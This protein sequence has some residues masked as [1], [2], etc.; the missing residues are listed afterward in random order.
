VA[1]RGKPGH[2]GG[3]GRVSAA[4]EMVKGGLGAG[5]LPQD[6]DVDHDAGAPGLVF[7]PGLVVRAEPAGLPSTPGSAATAT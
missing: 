3:A 7:L 6:D 2:G 4:S 1:E 5:R